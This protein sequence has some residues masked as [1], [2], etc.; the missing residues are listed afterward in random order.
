MDFLVFF[1]GDTEFSGKV[2]HEDTAFPLLE[3]AIPFQYTRFFHRCKEKFQRRRGQGY[4]TASRFTSASSG[5]T[6]TVWQ[7]E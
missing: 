2:V 7:V 3:P 4:F 6:F 5:V 1:Q